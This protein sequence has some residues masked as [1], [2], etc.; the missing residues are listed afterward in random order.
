MSYIFYDTETTGT[1]ASFDQILQ[2]AAIKTDV[3]L[4]ILDTFNVRCRLLPHVVPSPGAL[5]VTGVTVA[6]ITSAPLSHFEMMRQ[7]RTKMDKWSRDGA[8]FIGWNSM[9]FDETLLRQAYYQTLL[10]VYQTNTNGNGRADLMRIVQV[11]SCCAPNILAVPMRADGKTTFKLGLVAEANDIALANAHDALADTEATILIARVVKERAP[12]LWDAMMTNARK[13]GPL[14]LIANHHILTLNENVFGNQYNFVVAPITANS[15]NTAEWGM[16]DLQYD[17]LAYLEMTDND[18]SAAIG[19]K[20]KAIRRVS[21][22]A[23]PALLPVEFAPADVRGGR[24]PLEIYQARARLVQEHSTFRQRVARLLA[25]RYEDRP[26]S[27]HIEER[28]YDCF[29]SNPNQSRMEAFHL[30]SWERRVDIIRTID[31]DRYRQLGQRI[32]AAERPD[33]LTSDQR[34][35]WDSWRRERFFADGDLPWLTVPRALEE[36]EDLA[37]DAQPAQ[38]AQLGELR[39]FLNGLGS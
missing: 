10:P 23:H 28:I 36:L 13:N 37:R 7:V 19:G 1:R 22:N 31:D 21:V 12:V 35:R 34:S 6:H 8:V 32:V 25:A 26:A 2:F 29:P 14:N 38:Q 5:L 9:R 11:V 15:N 39:H 27:V 24:L 20:V 16:F 4:R 17:P 3:D 33:L 30:Q 18:L